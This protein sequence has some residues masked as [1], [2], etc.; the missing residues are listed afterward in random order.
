VYRY[1]ERGDDHPR[2]FRCGAA[3]SPRCSELLVLGVKRYRYECVRRDIVA[4]MRWS[5]EGEIETVLAS[6]ESRLRFEVRTCG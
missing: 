4:L 2:L 5:R 3:L 1:G 6:L